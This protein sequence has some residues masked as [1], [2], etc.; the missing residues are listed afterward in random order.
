MGEQNQPLSRIHAWSKSASLRSQWVVASGH[1]PAVAHSRA[2]RSAA[3]A[4]ASRASLAGVSIEELLF[5]SISPRS[6]YM[7]RHSRRD[8]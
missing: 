5:K 2:C 1:C 6:C 3:M 7:S 4:S 8:I